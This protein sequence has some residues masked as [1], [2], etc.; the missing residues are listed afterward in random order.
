MK[1][2]TITVKNHHD[3]RKWLQKHHKTERKVAV[4]VHKR[5]T[6]T[7]A[8]THRELIEEAICFGWID[9]TI[10]RLDDDRYI[11]NFSRRTEN[12]KWS[13]N[14]LRYARQLIKEKRMTKEGMKLY[15]QG[16]K[17]PTH[18][19]GIPKNPR[20][21]AQLKTALQKDPKAKN[22]FQAYP[23]STKRMMYR[24]ILRAKLPQTRQRRIAQIIAKARKGDKSI[25]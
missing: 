10:K 1:T 13:N 3:F 6:N 11:R 8:P 12:S 19:E 25:P 24:W 17:K 4:I 15:K 7:P 20:I 14:T 22:Q 9:T 16:L 21:P 18:D 2:K 5:H 23:P